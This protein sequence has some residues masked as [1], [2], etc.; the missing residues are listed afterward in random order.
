VS[1]DRGVI[2]ALLC[3]SMC[4]AH[5]CNSAEAPTAAL[6]RLTEARRLTASLRL[7]VN[8][9]ADAE[10][11]SVMSES[12]E[13]SKAFAGESA[14]ASRMALQ[15]TTALKSLLEQLEYPDELRLLSEFEDGF[16]Q[17]RALDETLL[18]LAVENTNLKAQRLSFGEAAAAASAV[19]RALEATVASVAATGREHAE[20]LTAKIELAVDGIR[21]LE[22]PHIAEPDDA[23]MAGLEARMTGYEEE[24]RR[25]LAS[26]EPNGTPPSAD[27][28]SAAFERFVA[29]HE[30]ILALSHRNTN[31]RSLALSLGQKRRLTAACDE[32]LAALEAALETR[33]FRATR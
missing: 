3:V 32:S 21:L 24:A 13:G 28:A 10:K 7:L 30:E 6:T 11:R 4:F 12:D 22:G 15:Q 23:G 29:L 16:A 1:L 8:K 18:G 17:S 20:L 27:S 31:V 14:A 5:G 33:G 26:L 25:L 19:R 9:S 2:A